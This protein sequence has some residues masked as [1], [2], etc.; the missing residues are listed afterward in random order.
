MKNADS[1]SKLQVACELLDSALEMY[2]QARYFSSLHLGG[3][4]EE[5]FGEYVRRS[6]K[7]S[8]MDSWRVDGLE[9]VNFISANEPWTPAEF[10]KVMNSSKNRTK[11][12][13]EVGD[14]EILFNAGLEAKDILNRAVFD[15][16]QLFEQYSL[17]ESQFILQFQRLRNTG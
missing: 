3:A 5:L 11:H 9:L 14:D 10:C 12:M 7:I 16:Y 4:A 8:A 13:D 6:G 15:F 17:E 1:I 2:C